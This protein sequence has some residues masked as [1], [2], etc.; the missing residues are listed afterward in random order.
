VSVALPLFPSL[1]AVIVAVP[2]ADEVTS[3]VAGSTVATEGAPELQMMLRP[4]SG[5]LLASSVV[6][7]AWVGCP[8]STVV[9]ASETETEATGTGVTV[10]EADPSFPS[11]AAVIF[12][13]PGPTAVTIPVP[14]TVATFVLSELHVTIRPVNTPARASWSV[15]VACV[16]VPATIVLS[17]IATLTDATGA[18]VTV[19]VATPVLPSL[20]AVIIA[21]PSLTA[22]TT[23]LL[24]TVATALLLELQLNGRPV[25]RPPLASRV[26]AV[27]CDVSTAVIVV[28]TRATVTEAT[29]TGTTVIVALPLLPSLVATISAVP[30]ATAVTTPVADT[31]ATPGS[32][33]DQTIARP[34]RTFPLPSRV[35]AVA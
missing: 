13:V 34:V 10:T 28:G 33:D 27:A 16:V 19:S 32:A 30:G 23:P 4:V 24:D 2:G 25:S 26:V 9:R 15:A 29:E 11:L 18:G 21:G 1:V 14:D 3:P 5:L 17:V 22:V 12:A 7:V 35:T 8:A 20:V 6:A 31:V